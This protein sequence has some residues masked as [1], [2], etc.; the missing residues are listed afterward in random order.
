[1]DKQ[2]GNLKYYNLSLQLEK[3]VILFDTYNGRVYGPSK[4]KA[5]KDAG[6]M[7]K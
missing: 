3:S 1:M 7:L 4:G 6:E 2:Y 5:R